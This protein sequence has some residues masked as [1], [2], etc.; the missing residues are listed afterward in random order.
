M[1]EIW[2]RAGGEAWARIRGVECRFVAGIKT[3]LLK[4]KDLHGGGKN[5][6]QNE[7]VV[8]FQWLSFFMGHNSWHS[9]FEKRR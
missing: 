4:T 1:R 7:E 2:R 3:V 5:V 9:I 8:C 6:G